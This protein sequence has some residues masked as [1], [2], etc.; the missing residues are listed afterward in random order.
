M[1]NFNTLEMCIAFFITLVAGIIA[2]IAPDIAASVAF[3]YFFS[4]A[5]VSDIIGHVKSRKLPSPYKGLGDICLFFAITF[6][7]I[8]FKCQNFV[9]NI[10]SL[11]FIFTDCILMYVQVKVGS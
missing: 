7:M 8:G 9:F 10:A 6:A 1:K 2:G 11:A 3:V 5:L 4:C